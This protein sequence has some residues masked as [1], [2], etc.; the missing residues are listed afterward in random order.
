[1]ESFK[2]NDGEAEVPVT[3]IKEAVETGEDIFVFVFVDVV[4]S[5]SAVN[6]LDLVGNSKVACVDSEDTSRL[7]VIGDDDDDFT[8][9]LETGVKNG[10]V[11]F[12]TGDS[13]FNDLSSIDNGK[14]ACASENDFVDGVTSSSAFDSLTLIGDDRVACVQQSKFVLVRSIVLGDGDEVISEKWKLDLE[15][16]LHDTGSSSDG[17]FG[18]KKG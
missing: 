18:T 2:N 14:M 3:L 1:M 9:K 17:E 11:D 6:S 12:V 16:F 4:I 15:G 8:D 5:N 13:A 10:F 7:W